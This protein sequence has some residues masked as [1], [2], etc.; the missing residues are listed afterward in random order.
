MTIFDCR[1]SIFEEAKSLSECLLPTTTVGKEKLNTI[2]T[3]SQILNSKSFNLQSKINIGIQRFM[4]AD[5]RFL[6]WL[7]YRLTN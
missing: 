4:I 1:F 6:R 2:Y 5:F 3:L 7:K